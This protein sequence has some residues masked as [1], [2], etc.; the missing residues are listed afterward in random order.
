[1]TE[2]RRYF[3]ISATSASDATRTTR[4]CRPWLDAAILALPN[5]TS[6]RYVTSASDDITLIDLSADHR[7]DAAWTYGPAGLSLI[8]I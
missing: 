4:G 2:T 7:F 5:G 6:E 8:H 3:R 1:M